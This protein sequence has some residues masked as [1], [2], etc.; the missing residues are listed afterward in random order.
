MKNSS[1]I[2]GNRTRDLPTC[3]A[4]PQPTAPPRAP[5][6][7]A[8]TVIKS[9][10][11]RWVAIVARNGKVSENLNGRSNFRDI[12]TNGGIIYKWIFKKQDDSVADSRQ[13]PVAGSFGDNN[14]H[15]FVLIFFL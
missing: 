13:G 4:V 1:D 9:R 6:L 5:S 14:E 7:N 10:N 2:I 11:L 15:S 3:S 12:G 8:I